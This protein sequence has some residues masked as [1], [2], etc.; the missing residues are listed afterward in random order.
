MNSLSFFP[1]TVYL[2]NS[3]LVSTVFDR[4]MRILVQS[5][6]TL[7]FYKGIGEW[8][9]DS[10]DAFDFISSSVAERICREHGLTNV[11]MLVRFDRPG[12]NDIFLNFLA[13]DGPPYDQRRS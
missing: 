11:R 1:E 7:L 10:E 6:E 2:V 4:E 12:A 3:R 5:R 8:T 9:S 13:K